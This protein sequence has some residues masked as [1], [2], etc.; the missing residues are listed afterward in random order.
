M[1]SPLIAAAILIGRAL[2]AQ[3]PPAVPDVKKEPAEPGI[4]VASAVVKAKC[5]GC[6]KDDGQGL[7]TRISWERTTPEGWQQIIKRMVRLNGLS[8]TPGEARDIVKSLS[9]THGLAPEEAKPV[10]WYWEKRQLESE[11]LPNDTLRDACAACHP[12]AQPNSWRRSKGEWDL[13]GNMHRGYFPVVEFTSYRRPPRVAGGGGARG[14]APAAPLEKEPFETALEYFTKSNGLH[15]PEWAQWQASRKPDV[16]GSRPHPQ[17]RS[18]LHF[19]KL[20]F[21][22]RFERV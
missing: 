1:R 6:H 9:E 21:D 5:G 19:P 10:A 12:I 8:L 4:A 2:S 14:A 17:S 7:M 13:L 20:Q 16:V 15:T 11:T 3:V 18:R 22:R